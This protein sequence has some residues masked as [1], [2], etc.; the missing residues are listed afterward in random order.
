MEMI[1]NKLLQYCDNSRL[2]VG[3]LLMVGVGPENRELNNIANEATK[4]NFAE[5]FLFL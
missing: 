5:K 3:V 1:D 2:E 4:I